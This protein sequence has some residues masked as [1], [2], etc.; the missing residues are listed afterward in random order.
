M[1]RM[2]AYLSTPKFIKYLTDLGE[3]VSVVGP[4]MRKD[5]LRSE[6]KKLNRW[7]PSAV[8]LPF[9]N[10]SNRNYAVLH[11]PHKEGIVF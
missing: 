9:I 8:Y 3:L 1:N 4:N 5:L 2:D 7:L 11:I 6:I 10:E